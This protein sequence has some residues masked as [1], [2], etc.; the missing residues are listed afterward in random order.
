MQIMTKENLA[1]LTGRTQPVA[2][3][4]WLKSQKWAFAVGAD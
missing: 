4:R 3:I 1:A 2:Q